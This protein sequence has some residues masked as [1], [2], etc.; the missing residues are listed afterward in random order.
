MG[1]AS[2]IVPEWAG[3]LGAVAI[4]GM[5]IKPVW[6]AIRARL[7][8]T[9]PQERIEPEPKHQSQPE[10]LPVVSDCCPNCD[11]SSDAGRS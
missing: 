8:P 5:S 4:L 3:L 2:E 6:G 9:G 1:Q 10:P 7:K 11:G